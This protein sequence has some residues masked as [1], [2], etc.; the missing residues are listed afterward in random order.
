MLEILLYQLWAFFW[1]NIYTKTVD[2][3][4]MYSDWLIKSLK[5]K[6]AKAKTLRL[7]GNKAGRISL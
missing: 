3:V 7:K 1:Y 2:A 6:T 5:P 4:F